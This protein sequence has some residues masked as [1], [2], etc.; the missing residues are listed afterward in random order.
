VR[1]RRDALGVD[2]LH[3]PDQLEDVVEL[4]LNRGGLRVADADAGQ[5]RDAAHLFQGQRHENRLKTEIFAVL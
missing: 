5:F 2:L 3:S 4:G 1:H